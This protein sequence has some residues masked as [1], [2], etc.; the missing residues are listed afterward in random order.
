MNTTLVELEF[1]ELPALPDARAALHNGFLLSMWDST[2][3]LSTWNASAGRFEDSGGHLSPLAIRSWALLSMP[4]DAASWGE[5]VVRA[6]LSD[7]KSQQDAG[8][9][10]PTYEHASPNNLTDGYYWYTDSDVPGSVPILV[11]VYNNEVH[12]TAWE[13]HYYLPGVAEDPRFVIGFANGTYAGPI[14]VPESCERTGLT[15]R[16]L[17]AETIFSK[18]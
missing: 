14:A 13:H 18:S 12:S 2:C 6:A 5:P 7:D 8:W 16:T 11:K 3:R 17:N 9:L 10:Q 4:L 1:V 15:I